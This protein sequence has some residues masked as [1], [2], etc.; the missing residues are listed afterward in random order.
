MREDVE[1]RDWVGCERRENEGERRGKRGREWESERERQKGWDWGWPVLRQSGHTREKRPMV[2]TAEGSLRPETLKRK[3]PANQR[4]AELE[5]GRHR[6]ARRGR[7][8]TGE[9]CNGQN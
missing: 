3:H 4:R 1:Y 8:R 9:I 5:L 2:H 6:M 7:R